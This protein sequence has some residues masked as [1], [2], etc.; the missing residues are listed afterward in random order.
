MTK[1]LYSLRLRGG[2]HTLDRPWVMAIINVTPDSFYADSKYSQEKA[3][4][5]RVEQVLQEGA[6]LVDLGAMSSRPGAAIITPEEEWQRLKP[7]LTAVV[8]AFP[9]ALFSVD[10]LHSKVA[11]WAVEEG[12]A[13]INDI[14]AGKVDAD[15]YTTAAALQVPYVLMHMQG[16]PA[17]MQ[18]E[19]LYGDVVTEV[20]DFFSSELNRLHQMGVHD[21]L[22]DPGFGFGK[23]VAHN[24]ALLKALPDFRMLG[25]P[26]VVGVSRKSMINKVLGTTPETA[27]NGT[28][29]LHTIALQGGAH[30]L[31]VHDVREAVEVVKLVQMVQ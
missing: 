31:R 22:I 4:L 5:E 10:T 29:V 30:I 2:V 21:V 26:I 27:L 11:R 18:Q 23:T 9:D 8:R 17:D 20:L 6:D 7:V 16:T 12:A 19:P 1:P 25:H 15:M 13:M 24:Y 3:V 28:T 14:S